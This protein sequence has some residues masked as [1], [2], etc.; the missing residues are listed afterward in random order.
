MK[1]FMLFLALLFAIPAFAQA[2]SPSL[3]ADES[4]QFD[5]ASLTVNA[6]A[7]IT[8]LKVPNVAVK[9]IQCPLS[10]IAVPGVYT[11]VVTATRNANIVNTGPGAATVTQ[12]S[13]G[14]SAP[15]QYTLGSAVVATPKNPSVGP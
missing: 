5:T 14:V 10:S 1:K 15:F 3:Y 8:C 2:A 6:G 7:P 12:G 4:D 13:S 11:L 9:N